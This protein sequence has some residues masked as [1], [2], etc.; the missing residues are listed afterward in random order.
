MVIHPLGFYCFAVLPCFLFKRNKV[1]CDHV[2][3]LATGPSAW[4]R[5]QD[6]HCGSVLGY[7]LTTT[8]LSSTVFTTPR[9]VNK[10]ANLDRVG[11]TVITLPGGVITGPPDHVLWDNF[12]SE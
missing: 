6:G 2:P 12:H 11:G 7:L 1:A 10:V 9:R 8:T 4:E 5:Y 3:G